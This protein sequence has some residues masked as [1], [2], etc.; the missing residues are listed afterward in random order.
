MA[1]KWLGVGQF[2]QSVWYDNVARPAVE[3]GLLAK[4][5][6]DDGVTGGTSNPSIFAK[7]VEDT[8]AYDAA[9]AAFPAD[10]TAVQIFE[11]LWIQDIQAACDVMRPAFDAS[12]GADGFISIEVEAD[13]A[14]DTPTTVKRAQEL[15]AAVD[16]PNVLIK[17]PGTKPGID[18]VRQLTAAGI[19]INVTLLFSV[20][21]YYEIAEAYAA[22]M[23]ER[24][25]AGKPVTGIQ[26]VASFFV[27]RIDSKVDDMLPEGSELRGKTAV[28]N[29]KIAYADVYQAIFDNDESWQAVEAA[30]GARQ[31]ALWA[32][33]STKNPAYS[34]CL[35]VDELIGP[36]TVNTVPDA[37]LEAYRTQGDP[38]SRLTEDLAGARAVM[39]GVADAGID[40]AAVTK[41]LED[42]G[43]AAFQKAYEGMLDAITKRHDA[44]K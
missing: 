9:I 6:V 12:N 44:V 14:F 39:Q 34:P 41:E 15:H 7:N 32:S 31:R 16:R 37:T 5:M 33:T 40:F 18:S 3:T 22:G 1:S 19:S 20:E 36:D 17:V 24:L 43:V 23:A 4:I 30:G 2:G 28:A 42:E 29:A 35:Y 11:P 25:A 13:L 27:S 38:A 21:R 10:A 26:S 8:D